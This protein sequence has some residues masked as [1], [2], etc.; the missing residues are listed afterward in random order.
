[1]LQGCCDSHAYQVR[2]ACGRRIGTCGCT[3]V[4]KDGRTCYCRCCRSDWLLKFMY[5]TASV[6][7]TVAGLSAIKWTH[8]I[9]HNVDLTHIV[10]MS[11]THTHTHTHTLSADAV[12]LWQCHT[13]QYIF[14]NNNNKIHVRTHVELDRLQQQQL[15]HTASSSITSM[16]ISTGASKILC[17]ALHD[18]LQQQPL[19]GHYAGQL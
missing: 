5:R 9:M 3:S 1:M 18:G 15:T 19:Y 7:F 16:L 8:R 4:P 13:N 14:N 6:Q 10:S 2:A 11:H 12:F 17:M